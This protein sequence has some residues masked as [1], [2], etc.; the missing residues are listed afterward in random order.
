MLSSPFFPL[1][2]PRFTQSLCFHLVGSW[3]Q[4]S[5]PAS[6]DGSFPGVLR[7]PRWFQPN[8][9]HQSP[10][11]R[12]AS[13]PPNTF[14]MLMTFYYAAPHLSHVTIFCPSFQHSRKKDTPSLPY[15]AQLS[16]SQ[17]KRLLLITDSAC[18]PSNHQGR[19]LSDPLAWRGALEPDFLT[20]LFLVSPQWSR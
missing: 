16:V 7:Q 5:I 3:H 17:V 19:A 8:S 6:L 10:L 12:P 2:H 9:S 14:N 20:L 18:R 4:Y 13:K 1:P 11:P 15:K